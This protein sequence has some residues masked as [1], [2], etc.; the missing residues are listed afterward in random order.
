M[1]DEIYKICMDAEIISKLIWF[2]EIHGYGDNDAD[3]DVTLVSDDEHVKI[4]SKE[5]YISNKVKVKI[6]QQCYS[7][8]CRYTNTQFY[9]LDAV[10]SSRK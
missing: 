6:N 8:L 4:Y 9:F 7:C 3:S 10:N 2:R 1:R 5:W